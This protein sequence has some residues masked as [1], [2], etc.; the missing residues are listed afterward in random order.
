MR[1]G[2]ILIAALLIGAATPALAQESTLELFAKLVGGLVD[3]GQ[4]SLGALGAGSVARVAGNAFEVRFPQGDPARLVFEQPL[5]CV[6]L[7]EIN[8]PGQGSTT[9]RLDLNQ[10][11]SIQMLDQGQFNELNAMAM[12]FEGPEGTAQIVSVDG[13]AQNIA[14]VASVVTSLTSA[15]LEAAAKALRQA[16][17]GPKG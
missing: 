2:R 8:I 1:Y 3:G 14:P 9:I 16:C 10:V 12:Q 17:P 6:F 5:A 11:T 15:D 13:T 7:E 4:V